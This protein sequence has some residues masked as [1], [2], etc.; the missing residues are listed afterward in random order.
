MDGGGPM[1]EKNESVKAYHVRRNTVTFFLWWIYYYCSLTAVHLL[2]QQKG[3]LYDA[4]I[5]DVVQGPGGN[6]KYKVHYKRWNKRLDE[7]LPFEKITKIDSEG[8]S[9]PSK[10]VSSGYK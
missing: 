8:F 6:F 9:E 10:Q 7:F 4:I 5:T 1:F 3:Q 2:Q